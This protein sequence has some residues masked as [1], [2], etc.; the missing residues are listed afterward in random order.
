METIVEDTHDLCRTASVLWYLPRDDKRLNENSCLFGGV[1]ISYSAGCFCYPSFGA[2]VVRA[3][4]SVCLKLLGANNKMYLYTNS[5]TL[6]V[7]SYQKCLYASLNDV[8]PRALD[9]HLNT[10]CGKL[11]LHIPSFFFN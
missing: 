5:L 7:K 11:K 9:K 10:H 6:V 4:R 1:D 8:L 2:S 3:P